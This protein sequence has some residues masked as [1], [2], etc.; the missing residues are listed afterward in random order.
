MIKTL[1]KLGVPDDVRRMADEKYK[2]D[3]D[4]LTVF[5][6]GCLARYDDT[7]EYMA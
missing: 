4:G 3:P 5:I 7:H 1:E 6:L 2:G